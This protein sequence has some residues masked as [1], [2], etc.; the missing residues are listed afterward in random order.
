MRAL[1]R[2]GSG[3]PSKATD[4]ILAVDPKG[5]IKEWLFLI[6]V[7]IVCVRAPVSLPFLNT[8][9]RASRNSL[10]CKTPGRLDCKG[11]HKD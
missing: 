3:R 8:C 11:W 10:G 5:M 2:L 1:N 7:Y 6:S 4:E 9:Y